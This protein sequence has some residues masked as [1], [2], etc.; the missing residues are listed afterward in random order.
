MALYGGGGAAIS[1]CEC[2]VMVAIRRERAAHFDLFT[3]DMEAINFFSVLTPTCISHGSVVTG[4]LCEKV[5]KE[6]RVDRGGRYGSEKYRIKREAG[7]YT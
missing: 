7:C 6:N 5:G 4:A 1:Y 3:Y 2:E